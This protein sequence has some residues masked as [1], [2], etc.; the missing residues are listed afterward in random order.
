MLR[1]VSERDIYTNL[2]LPQEIQKAG[3]DERDAGFV[4]ELTYGALRWK[5]QNEAIAALCVDRPW[6]QLDEPIRDLLNLGVHQLHHMR[7]PT[8]A[9]VSATVELARSVVGE[10]R[11][12]LVNAVL[13]KVSSKDLASWLEELAGL[14]NFQAL[15]YS[16]PEW[17][18]NA[19]RDALDDQSEIEALL[20]SNNTP[21]KVCLVAR[22]IDREELIRQGAAPAP[23]SP[24]AAYWSGSLSKLDVS[25]GIGSAAFGVQDEGSQLVTLALTRVPLDED[26]RWL[27]LCAGPGGKAALLSALAET[28][29]ISVV[30]NE[31]Q[32][33]RAKLVERVVGKNT[34]VR[35]GDGR[36]LEDSGFDRTLIDA[37][38]TGIGALRRR[39]EARWRRKPRDIA[40]LA[41]L[42][43]EL[44]N[45]GIDATRRGGVIAYITCSPHLAETKG[46][47]NEVLASRG[48]VEL[49]QAAD[50][51][52]EVPHAASGPY[53]Q[54]WPHRHGTDAMF[55][56][57]MRRTDR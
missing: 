41:P 50:Y 21:A 30:A 49:L 9:A 29:G 24:R 26:R 13:R 45:A 6:E 37:P 14:P 44:L 54:L 48:D 15:K 55:L 10:S 53:V 51:L 32:E 34:T 36:E 35:V 47:V 3:L 12:S 33:H 19:Y 28:K 57:L 1:A 38:C 25:G 52:P 46:V 8:H 7:I 23:Y 56:A 42:Q 40:G 11:A 31:V 17:I 4:T 16:H 39:P 22:S 5:A 20:T 18:I 43:R 2:V 27:D